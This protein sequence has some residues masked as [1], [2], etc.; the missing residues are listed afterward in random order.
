MGNK[1]TCGEISKDGLRG[2]KNA[3]NLELHKSNICVENSTTCDNRYEEDNY[4]YRYENESNVEE[5]RKREYSEYE[6]KEED[7]NVVDNNYNNNKDIC[8]YHNDIK[9]KNKLIKKSENDYIDKKHIINVKRIL[10]YIK[11]YEEDFVCFFKKNNA[12]SIIYLKYIVLNYKTYIM[13]IEKGVIYIGEVNENNEKN[14]LG[15]IITPDQCIY[16][17]E[18]EEDKIT[19]F[20]LYIHYSKSKYIGYWRR[21][22][23]NRYGIFIHPDGTFYKGFWLN[24]KQNKNGIEYVY[25]NYVYIGNY[26]KGEKNTFGIFV[27]NNECMYIGNIKNNYLFNRGIYFFNKYKIYIG[28]W[29]SNCVDGKCEIIWKDNRQF[30]GYHLNN[31]KEGLGIY[32]WD[33]GR[34]YFGNW[35]N[36]KQHGSGIFIIIK[37]FKEYEHYKKYPIFLLFKNTEK[38]K[39]NFLLNLSKENIFAKGNIGKYFHNLLNNYDNYNFYNFLFNLLYINFY[40]LCS[41]FFDY[42]KKK[43]IIDFKTNHD[44]YNTIKDHICVVTDHYF[45]NQ[46]VSNKM[47]QADSSFSFL[48]TDRHDD[49]ETNRDKK[50]INYDNHMDDYQKHHSPNNIKVKNNE[51]GML[52]NSTDKQ[53]Y[54]NNKIFKGYDNEK[55]MVDKQKYEN[56]KIF[57]G[58]DNEK[59]M[60][61][62]QKYEN[63]KIFKGYENDQGPGHHKMSSPTHE[64]INR[65]SSLLPFQ[66]IQRLILYINSINLNDM[67]EKD[68]NKHNPLFSYASK[69]ILLK[70][71][72]WKN[73]KLKKWVYASDDSISVVNRDTINND[74]NVL[75]Y[76]GKNKDGRIK[77]FFKNKTDDNSNN[78][79]NGNNNMKSNHNMNGNNN[80]KSNHNMKSNNIINSNHNMKSNNIINS[81]TSSNISRKHNTYC[82]SSPSSSSTKSL[83][84]IMKKKKKKKYMNEKIY[85]PAHQIEKDMKSKGVIPQK[86]N[87]KYIY[88]NNEKKDISYDNDHYCYHSDEDDNIYLHDEEKKNINIVHDTKNIKNN[89]MEKSI[90][91]QGIN[92]KFSNDYNFQQHHL[93]FI[94]NI[95]EYNNIQLHEKRNRK[96]IKKNEK[97]KKNKLNNKLIHYK[98]SYN[99]TSTSDRISNKSHNSIS[100]VNASVNSSIQSLENKRKDTTYNTTG[101]H[102]N[103]KRVLTDISYKH[104]Q[105]KNKEQT[106]IQYVNNIMKENEKHQNDDENINRVKNINTTENI[107]QINKN[108][109]MNFYAKSG[110]NH[111]TYLNLDDIKKKNKQNIIIKKKGII[112]QNKINKKETVSNESLM[113]QIETDKTSS[114]NTRNTKNSTLP[115][116][117]KNYDLPKKGFSLIWSLKKSRRHS[118]LSTKE[119]ILYQN[120]DQSC[121]DHY[122]KKY[123]QNNEITDTQQKKKSFFRNFLSVNKNKKKNT[124]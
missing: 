46:V 118:P 21:G 103:D 106:E 86:D 79:M 80:M 2:L 95:K 116:K 50:Y 3:Y 84:K 5:E 78:N 121:D 20:G 49:T 96:K 31:L 14:G 68:I 10:M 61:D 56:N 60:V 112:R 42:I 105:K 91:A 6:I 102:L 7:K 107:N 59:I 48:L 89:N 17:G 101:N 77:H 122:D 13:V 43:N 73:G 28:K 88:Y 27:W 41:T 75:S 12:T 82:S 67:S 53:K 109:E 114:R 47:D 92:H 115:Y 76:N 11:E 19:G 39:K 83:Y 124:H 57:K 93:S 120:D 9:D 97:K 110:D 123:V 90:K 66:D 32:K 55:I 23:A 54:E 94:H 38:M 37:N 119:K 81:N 36:N 70:Y 69:N 40:E 108:E 74:T 15:I 8:N 100:F 45:N 52:I 33:D 4:F 16:I 87:N 44:F 1:L 51:K 26:C 98:Y 72:K 29:K 25:N 34:I 18:F 62:K 71:G 30:F 24:D 65:T 85:D 117:Y 22:K 35:L 111:M 64:Q 104:I 99:T 63:N 113:N 58:Y